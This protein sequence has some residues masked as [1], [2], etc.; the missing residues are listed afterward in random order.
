MNNVHENMKSYVTEKSVTQ[1]ISMINMQRITEKAKTIDFDTNQGTILGRPSPNVIRICCFSVLAFRPVFGQQKRK[2]SK[3]DVFSDVFLDEDQLSCFI[4]NKGE[5]CF[6][7][8]T[9]VRPRA[10]FALGF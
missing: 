1:L 3:S 6:L 2:F 5:A 7:Q 4:N 8:V 10:P 9:S